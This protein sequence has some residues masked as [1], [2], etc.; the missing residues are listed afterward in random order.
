M[1]TRSEMVA[2]DI[3][4]KDLLTVSEHWS[5]QALIEFFNQ[6]KITG[7][8]VLS[9]QKEFSGVVSLS[10]ILIFDGK[11]KHSMNENPTTQYYYNSLEGCSPD[12]LG[13]SEGSQHKNHLV[14][15][16]MTKSIISAPDTTPVTELAE[17]MHSKGVHRI[18]ITRNEQIC[19]AVSTLDILK[20]LSGITLYRT[21]SN[22]PVE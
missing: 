8:P 18:F 12:E 6:H 2:S 3:M 4:S 9:A 16:I 14:A 11:P 17:T 10:D 22:V 1:N 13:F 20:L 5:I 7:A 19:G 21:E 15:E